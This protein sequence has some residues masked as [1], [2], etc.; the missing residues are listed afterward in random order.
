MNRQKVALILLILLVISGIFYIWPSLPFNQKELRFPDIISSPDANANIA[1]G[2]KLTIKLNETKLS[3][4]DSIIISLDKTRIHKINDQY[5]YELET[6]GMPLG[7]HLID[8][9]V[10]RGSKNK[11]VEL[12]F[13]IVSD[14][15]PVPAIHSITKTISR[16]TNSY[17]QGF[18]L[19]DGILY[20]SGGQIGRS[21]I[22]KVN[23]KTGIVIKS[24]DT[25]KSLFAEGLTILNDKVYQLTWQNGVCLIYDKDLNLIKKTSFKSSNGE[26][27][28]L[29][30]DG[31]S[32][33]VSDGSNKLSYLNPETLEIEKKVSV[34]A[35]PKEVTLLNELEYVNGFIYANIYTTDQIAK[36]EATTGKVISVAN[37]TN[38]DKANPKGDVLNGI[39]WN[40][41][42]KN[43]LITGKSWGKIYEAS[44]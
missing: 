27:W 39:A 9:E 21:L 43:F 2:Q 33:I 31:K 4:Q 10:F 25:D 11:K 40:P 41:A 6:T 17:T 42:S 13:F 3:D 35:G 36:I 15:Q 8:V 20:E 7:H 44:F 26:G 23:P 14:I 12:P 19:A 37:I 28:G 1:V 22:R 34:Y 30:N 5:S 29:C 16:D 38:L 32:L 18:E 24:V